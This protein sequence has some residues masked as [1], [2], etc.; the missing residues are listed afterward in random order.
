[1]HQVRSASKHGWLPVPNIH[2]LLD[3]FAD[4]IKIIQKWMLLSDFS[5]KAQKHHDI[6]HSRLDAKLL[7]TSRIEHP[8][9]DESSN[10]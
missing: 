4:W 6:D 3:V 7:A 2:P 8:N 9:L 5:I 10:C 1:M